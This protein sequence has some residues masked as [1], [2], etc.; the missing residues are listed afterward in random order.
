MQQNSSDLRESEP[1]LCT[2]V[3]TGENCP[4]SDSATRARIV[5]LKW[6]KPTDLDAITE[7]QSHIADINALGKQWVLWLNSEDGGKAILDFIADNFTSKRDHYINQVKDTV[8]AGRIATNAAI[9]SSIWELMKFCKYTRKFADFYDEIMQQ[10]INDH[11]LDASEE[12]N[13]NTEAEK[14]ISWLKAALE[15]NQY[16]ISGLSNSNLSIDKSTEAQKAATKMHIGQCKEN[17]IWITPNVL[18]NILLPAYHKTNNG[19]R[20]DK[21]SLRRQLH[22]RDYILYDEKN[23]KYTINQRVNGTQ[24]RVIVFKKYKLYP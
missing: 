3:I 8:N 13:A 24:T 5:L 6:E 2:L 20:V 10:A 4:G 1:Y 18:D 21:Q 12:V 14:F 16:F 22:E 17:E 19:V 7:A 23:K 9:L 15:T 11:I